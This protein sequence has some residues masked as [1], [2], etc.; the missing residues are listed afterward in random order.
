MGERSTHHLLWLQRPWEKRMSLTLPHG[1]APYMSTVS[2]LG[3]VQSVEYT[4]N[5][6]SSPWSSFLISMTGVTHL[7]VCVG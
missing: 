5:S 6:M 1:D 4:L 7:F 3:A 2:V